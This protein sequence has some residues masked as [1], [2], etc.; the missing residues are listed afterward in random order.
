MR[1]RRFPPHEFGSS[2]CP[3]QPVSDPIMKSPAFRFRRT[4]G[5]LG[6]S[7]VLGSV[8]HAD[9]AAG[10]LAVTPRNNL[11][12]EADDPGRPANTRLLKPSV[13]VD[14]VG[15]DDNGNIFNQYK[16]SSFGTWSNYDEAKANPFPVLPDPLTLKNGQP[17]K[18]AATWWQRRRPEIL[19][20]FFAEI[21]GRIPTDTPAITWEVVAS[22][23]PDGTRTK[24]IVGHIDNSRY[25]AATPVI[26]LTLTLPAQTSG[27][28]PVMVVVAPGGGGGGARRAGA[29]VAPTAAGTS[30]ASPPAARAGARGPTGPTPLQQALARGWGFASFNTASVQADSA[31]GLTSGIIGL[32]NRGQP[33][34]SPEEWGV[35]S[36][37]VWGLSRAID[38][39][40]TDRDVDAKRLGVEGHSRWGKTA[41]WAAACDQRWAIVYASCSGEGGAKLFRRNWGET[42]DNIAGSYWMAASFRKYGG[43]WN[44]LPVDSHELIALVAPRPAFITGATQDPWADPHGEFLA[45]VAAGPVYRLLGKKDIGTAEMPA[46]DVALVSGDVAFRKHI[47]THSDGPDWPV[48][49]DYAARYF[50][51][52]PG[53]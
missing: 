33:R 7:V 41:L 44:D 36:A 5:L 48:F 45:A 47:G 1:E 38:Y 42:T 3:E 26:N 19:A 9:T 43:H 17:V 20:D 27:P 4:I 29:A 6:L 35:L 14:D 31:A 32:M 22:T 50:S 30:P 53:K 11:P 12:P 10:V 40:E 2:F 52:P 23:Q 21:Y 39:L 25:P 16:R 8:L 13:W 46:P 28:V 37:W 34:R 18:D 49:L 24:T 15:V 51:M